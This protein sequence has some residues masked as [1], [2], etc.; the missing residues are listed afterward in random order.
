MLS[1]MRVQGTGRRLPLAAAAVA[2]AAFGH[3]LLYLVAVPDTQARMTVLAETGHGYWSVA[4]AAAIVLGLFSLAGTAAGHLLAGLGRTGQ[5]P[6]GL[7]PGGL[8]SMARR[9][10]LLQTGI[11]LVQEAVERLAAGTPLSLLEHHRVLLDG[12]LVQ[13]LVALGVAAVLHLLGRAAEAVG[14]ALR[15]PAAPGRQLDLGPLPA[16]PARASRRPGAYGHI[17]APPLP[18]VS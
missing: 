14:R 4:V 8:G 18:Q 2:G 15:R 12:I 16:P 17:R 3:T 1:Q 13:V 6:A 7:G 9:L 5:P 10:A 11:F